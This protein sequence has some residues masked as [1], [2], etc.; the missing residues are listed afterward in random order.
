MPIDYDPKQAAGC[1]PP[2]DYD[3][4]LEKV[5]DKVSKSSGNDMQ[6]WTLKVYNSDGQERTV[7]DYV[8]ASA[9]FK[10]RQLAEALGLKR[11]FEAKNFQADDHAGANL[12]V[13]LTI[14]SQDGYDDKNKVKRYLPAAAPAIPATP[15]ARTAAPAQPKP[16][17]LK[18]A[19]KQRPAPQSPLSEEPQFTDDD[20]PFSRP[21]N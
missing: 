8:T 10:I 7:W 19:V 1:W 18:Q 12:R 17:T 3:A 15:P 21:R 20:I 9:A 16:G 4:V 14:E 13:E 11:E 6:V 5:E 2:G